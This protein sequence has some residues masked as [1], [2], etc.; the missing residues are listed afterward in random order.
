[1]RRKV[2]IW[3]RRYSYK[4]KSVILTNNEVR[5]LYLIC[6]YNPTIEDCMEKSELKYQTV[7][8]HK[9]NL[10]HKLKEIDDKIEIVL[11]DDHYKIN[12][13]IKIIM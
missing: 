7:I 5:M 4:G 3:S 6:N 8:V 9:H 13:N 2:N 1:M 10:I 12:K 11:I